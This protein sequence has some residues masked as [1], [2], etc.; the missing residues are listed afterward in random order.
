M[1]L[2]RPEYVS[3]LVVYLLNRGEAG[4]REVE[5]RPKGEGARYRE[6]VALKLATRIVKDHG[7]S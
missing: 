2:E 6:A 3:D 7:I 1:S 5:P 4:G